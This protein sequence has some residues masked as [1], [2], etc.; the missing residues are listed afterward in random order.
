M[1]RI[2]KVPRQA[3]LPIQPSHKLGGS[4]GGSGLAPLTRHPYLCG[5][6]CGRLATGSEARGGH[7]ASSPRCGQRHHGGP[8]SA[9]A[10]PPRIAGRA[11][12]RWPGHA[13]RRQV[14]PSP[15]R[16]RQPGSTLHV[17]VPR[18]APAARTQLGRRGVQEEGRRQQ[19]HCTSSW[20][21]RLARSNCR[22]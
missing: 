16:H 17:A 2:K 20:P 4:T 1:L 10:A 15:S 22:R 13:R 9:E 19:M 6:A 7:T 12:N 8:Q 18:L 3:H 5:A 11:R 14:D 21:R